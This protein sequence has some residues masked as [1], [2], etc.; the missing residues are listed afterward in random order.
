MVQEGISEE[1]TLKPMPARGEGDRF[2]KKILGRRNSICKGRKA[3]RCLRNR[4]EQTVPCDGTDYRGAGQAAAE[5]CEVVGGV[6]SGRI[7]ALLF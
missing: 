2:G 6:G 7:L 4:Q 1:V 3:R 5:G